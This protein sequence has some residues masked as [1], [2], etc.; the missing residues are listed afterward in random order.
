MLHKIDENAAPTV[1]STPTTTTATTTSTTIMA[2]AETTGNGTEPTISTHLANATATIE[3]T[4]TTTTATAEQETVAAVVVAAAAN[5][6]VAVAAAAAAAE[7]QATETATATMT[8]TA[9]NIP[10]PLPLSAAAAEHTELATTADVAAANS[11]S[12]A[13]SA[14]EHQP[15][16]E[17][18]PEPAAFDVQ[19]RTQQQQKIRIYH[20]AKQSAV[21]RTDSLASNSSSSNRS[22]AGST[23]AMA[24]SRA[25]SGYSTAPSLLQRKFSDSSFNAA[26]MPRRVS[27]PE[28]D[29]EL[30]TG[31]LEPANPWEKV[32]QVSSIAEIS[33]LYVKSCYKHHT[34]PLKNI[35]EHLK[36][37]DLHLARQPLLSLKGIQL[38]P[39]DCEPLEEIFMRIQYKAI[40]LSECPLNESC[41]SALCQMIEYYEAANEL[42]IS[43]NKE[44][45]TVRGWGLCTHMVGRSQELQM[46]NAEGNQISKVGAENLGTALSLSNLHTLK[47]EHCGLKG[48]PLTNFCC[49]LYHNKILKE[50]WLGY[51]D[52]DCTD[53]QHIADMLRFNHSIE[54]IDI[55]N[56]NIRDEGAMYLV[57]ALILQATELE[58]RSGLPLQRARAIEDDELV[59]PME[60]TASAQLAGRS[61]QCSNQIQSEAHAIDPSTTP[62]AIDVLETVVE[63][64]PAAGTAA[65]AAAAEEPS[66][67]EPAVAL[68]VDVDNDADDDNTETDTVRT[69]RSGNQ[70]ATGQSM[71]DKLLSM[72]SDSSSEEAP[73]NISTDT[74][75]ACC[76]EDISEITN[77][78]YDAAGKLQSAAAAAATA[79]TDES[80]TTLVDPILDQLTPSIQQQQ[81]QSSQNERN[82]CDITPSTEAKTVEP[83]ETCVQN[84]NANSHNNNNNNNSN[85][86]SNNS[87]HNHNNNP[88]ILNQIAATEVATVAVS[89]S[90]AASIFEVTAEE[91]DCINGMAGPSG[92]RP[93]DMNKNAKNA[94]DDFED[95]HSTDSAFESA[96]EGDISR[97]LPDEF[98]RLSVSL[99]STRLD[100][101]AKEMAIETATIASESTECLLVAEEA[102]TPASTPTPVVH[103]QPQPQLET[104]EVIVATV[105]KV[106]IAA[107]EKEPSASPCPSPTPT[108]PPPSTSPGG[109]S[110]G[111]RRTESSCAYL[112]QSTRN[113][114]QSSDSLCSENSL[115]GSTSAADPHLAEKL[116]KNDTLS[117]RQLVDATLEAAN[118][119]PSGL[120]ALALWSNNLTK[121]CGPCIAELL[122]RSSSLELLNI[123]KNCLSNDFVATI[124][125]SLTRNTTLTTLGLQSAHLSAKGIET[126]ASI[127][128]FGGNSKLQRID[129][130]DNKLEVESLNIIAEVLKSNKTITQIDIN[131]EPK[132]LTIGSD[133]HLDYTRVL[134]T[135]RSMC[136]RNEKMQAEE[137]ELAEKAANVGGSSSSN[138][139]AGSNSS[140]S[141]GAIGGSGIK[142]RCRGGYY[143]GSRKISLTCHSRPLVDAAT[144]T[145]SAALAVTAM[146]TP[147]A[148]LEVKRKTNARL[149]SPG[150]SPPTI[151]PSSSPNRS[152]FHV[153][154]VNEISSPL[155]SPLAQMPPQHPPTPRSASSCMS[156]PTASGVSSSS[157][158]NGGIGA[159]GLL[160]SQS[161]LCAMAVL[162]LPTSSSLPSMASVTSSTQTVKRLSVSPRSRFHVSRIYED[163]Q[164]P[165]IHLPPTPMLKSARKAAA[166]AAQLAEATT[167]TTITAVEPEPTLSASTMTT[168]ATT[169]A[170]PISS[171]II[172]EP[173]PTV[174]DNDNNAHQQSTNG[175]EPEE[176][177]IQKLSPNS[178]STSSSSCS[179]SPV[180]VSSATSSTS[181]AS[182]VTT[183]NTDN[184]G[185]PEEPATIVVAKSCPI[186]VFG[187]NDI[188][189]TKDSAAG[190]A[191]SAAASISTDAGNPPAESTPTATGQQQQQQQLQQPATRARKSSWIANPTT[192]DKL[193]TLFNPSAIFQRSS[194]PESKAAPASAVAPLTNNAQNITTTTT[195]NATTGGSGD[196]NVTL[197]AT[198]KTTPPSRGNGGSNNATTTAAT[199]AGGA[200]STGSLA[201]GASGLETGAGS[202]SFLDTASRQL[203]DFGKQVFRQNLSFNNSGD[204]MG[205]AAQLDVNPSAVAMATSPILSNVAESP[206]PPE[207]NAVHMPLSLKRELKENISPEHTINE[208]TLHTL[209]KLSRVEDM[210]LK[211]EAAA[212]LGDIE[213]VMHSEVSDMPETEQQQQQQQ[214]PAQ[215]QQ[216]QPQQEDLGAGLGH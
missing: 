25:H 58:R 114:S 179:T 169:T 200:G 162:P 144:G 72:N 32:C 153:S 89:S 191:L 52:L 44:Q 212:E 119:A 51:N 101:M 128:T 23:E 12:A 175:M 3:P 4:T 56:N 192:V 97:H 176:A 201:T 121:E 84:N 154:R 14:S 67:S 170:M 105:P 197:L 142:N 149:R 117:R 181:S 2:P 130:R 163:P 102:A 178:P 123:G 160:G 46:L 206:S 141:N 68:L 31:Y 122:S 213:I 66:T 106:T 40:D 168:A 112:N 118:R 111:L 159:G 90:G 107:K 164:T 196:V 17:P 167:T 55:S 120:K 65:G 195:T 41:L 34:Q 199:A 172:V 110:S 211:A 28:S 88:V 26:T 22:E 174:A 158:S 184:S 145:V 87:N 135:V 190:A 9:N 54:L 151:S 125:D 70:S 147:A 129:I 124:K 61:E 113:R 95:T 57:Q 94:G 30:V 21:W 143:L 19:M 209:Q 69:L 152:R 210:T 7:G 49:K 43:Y 204:G 62:K 20:G 156:I 155:T 16:A 104:P 78:V 76:S 98:S 93:L 177:A 150:P 91:S 115:D 99:E 60:T 131:D 132:R 127:L 203:R 137:L 185:S 38:T 8:V 216:Q 166:A 187:D 171:V 116:T 39:N 100:D 183:D 73:S 59:S 136:S 79:S 53:A 182:N 15:E 63:Q 5:A 47:L 86:N 81:Q 180:S 96:S 198:R 24:T 45:M 74:L 92:S 37:L 215:Q 205:A 50:L 77:D 126:L 134:G 194:S 157:S 173:S 146:P 42:D 13:R 208:E 80:T 189:L 202:S 1:T 33:E 139:N 165:P 36:A 109:V 148:K 207:C 83:N 75:A 82:L 29:K 64:Q 103:M 27:F 18:E 138:N 186:A 6:A 188:T 140:S 214:Q 71:L 193:L 35:M 10:T 108:P 85:S 11:A 133:A 161:S 48:P